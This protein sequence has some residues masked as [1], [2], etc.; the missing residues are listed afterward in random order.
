M[1]N[2]EIQLAALEEFRSFLN[3]FKEEIGDKLTMYSNKFFSLREAG[4]SV[5]VAETY[6]SDFCE[7]NT[8]ILR[9]LIDNITQ[10]D[11][12]YINGNIA[13]TNEAI[14]RARRG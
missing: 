10:N 11:L 14:E 13:S 2:L 6:L 3:N 4:L 7:P 8:Q 9:N 1:Q 12:P 5:Q